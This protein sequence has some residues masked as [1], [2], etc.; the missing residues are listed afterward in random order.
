[1]TRFYREIEFKFAVPDKQAFARLL[2]QLDLPA[3]L[4]DTGVTQNNHFFDSHSH[5]LHKNHIAI[6]LRQENGNSLLTIKGEQ[7][8]KSRN[9]AILTDRIEEEVVLPS[10]LSRS[11][12]D[13]ELS[14][15][16]VIKQQFGDKSQS[17]LEKI[18]TA[19]EQEELVHIGK[20]S[21][22]RVHLP[23][24]TLPLDNGSESVVFELDSS[25]FPGSSTEYELEIE[26]SEHSDAALIE[27]IELTWPLEPE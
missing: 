7:F 16:Q 6:R 5:C 3:A 17:I 2:Q 12:L 19:C 26:I 20:F 23:P 25:T 21:N 18:R 4:L 1:M 10:T 11:L 27:T 13:G 24:V 15:Q 9:S 14:P 22:I 8:N